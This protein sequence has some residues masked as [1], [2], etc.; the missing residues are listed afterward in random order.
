MMKFIL[1]SLPN[2]KDEITSHEKNFLESIFKVKQTGMFGGK[3][4]KEINFSTELMELQFHKCPNRKFLCSFMIRD[5]TNIQ[6]HEK[7]D[8]K[9]TIHFR[10]PV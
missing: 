2:K 7:K 9:L 6:F 3:S 10:I 1:F 5:I 8:D 4:E